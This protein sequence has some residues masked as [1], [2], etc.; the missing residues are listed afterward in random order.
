MLIPSLLGPVQVGH[1]LPFAQRASARVS[2]LAVPLF[3]LV[4]EGTPGSA[5]VA[6]AFLAFLSLSPRLLSWPFRLTLR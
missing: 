2:L 4:P 1:P 3:L 5:R 6:H